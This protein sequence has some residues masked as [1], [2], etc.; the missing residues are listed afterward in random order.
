LRENCSSEERG[1]GGGTFQSGE[2]LELEFDCR[3]DALR[4]LLHLFLT[5]YKENKKKEMRTK[6]E[7]EQEEEMGG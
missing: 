5:L 2:L 4:S 6:E 1:R 7:E 3:S